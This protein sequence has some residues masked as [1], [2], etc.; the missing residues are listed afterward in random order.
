MISTCPCQ[1][2]AFFQQWW[3]D[4]SEA[5]QNT[6]RTLVSSGEL[7]M[8]KEGWKRLFKRRGMSYVG[9]YEVKEVI[10]FECM[11][12]RK[13]FKDKMSKFQ[14]LRENIHQEYRE[15]VERKNVDANKR[16]IIPI[17][18]PVTRKLAA[19]MA[20]INSSNLSSKSENF[21]SC[22]CFRISQIHI[23]TAAAEKILDTDFGLPRVPLA[24]K[25]VVAKLPVTIVTKDVLVKLGEDAV[26]SICQENLVANDKMQ[27]LP[28]KHMFHP[29]CLK[30]WL[31][32]HNSC[33]ICQHELQTD[34]H[35]YENWK[36]RE[37]ENELCAANKGKR[38]Q[39][40]VCHVSSYDWSILTNSVP[41]DDP[42]VRSN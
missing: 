15:V 8:I 41:Q 38:H 33:P 20:A 18:R 9:V 1:N 16:P 22:P 17:H 40:A 11:A 3:E 6:F 29:P 2:Q 19:Q 37:K 28:C 34:D 14:T 12:L 25:E 24:S 35:A 13:K 5:M 27:E 32:V 30:P 31:D 36:E 42:S 26:C 10:I 4:Q 23:V 21:F 39:S 7:E